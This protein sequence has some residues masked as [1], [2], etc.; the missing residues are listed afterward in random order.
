[1]IGTA[2]NAAITSAGA[3]DGTRVISTSD[4]GSVRTPREREMKRRIR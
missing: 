1:M 2:V 4:T 3:C